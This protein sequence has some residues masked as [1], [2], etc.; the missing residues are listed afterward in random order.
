MNNREW[1]EP[2]RCSVVVGFVAT[3][4]QRNNCCTSYALVDGVS[5][6]ISYRGG[7]EIKSIMHKT[8]CNTH[9]AVG[10]SQDT[11]IYIPV[12]L[13]DGDG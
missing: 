11:K 12:S 5:L 6:P 3:V 4:L 9:M 10:D 1:N 8:N 7:N 2:P 13:C